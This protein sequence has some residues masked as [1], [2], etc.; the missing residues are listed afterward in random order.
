VKRPVVSFDVFDTLLTRA[1]AEPH[2]LF[3]ALGEALR[4]AG[5]WSGEPADFALIRRNAERTAR[6]EVPG[7]EV[8]LTEIHERLAEKLHW[9][10]AQRGAALRTEL[11]LEAAAIRPVAAKIA[12][13]DEA[14]L[15]CGRVLFLSD[16][17]LPVEFLRAALE[18]AGFFR[19]GDQLFVSGHTGVGKGGGLFEHVRRELG[20]D[21][22]SWTHHGDNALADAAAPRRHGIRAH[23]HSAGRLSRREHALRGA[24]TFAPPWRSRLAAA[25]RLGRLDAPSSLTAPDRMLWNIGATVA[26]PL[27]WAF[28]RWSLQE[29]ARRGAHDAYFLARG[30][31]IFW[32]IAAALRDPPALRRHYLFTSRLAFAGSFDRDNPTRL[33]ELAAP[34][35]AHHS[36]QQALTNLGL[37]PSAVELPDRWP[38]E[39]WGENLSRADRA[40]LADWLLGAKHLPRVQAALA[41]RALLAARYLRESGFANSA[42]AAVIDTGWMGTI[43]RNIEHLVGETDSPVA[44]DGFYLGLSSARE[45]ATQ[46]ERLGFTNVFRPLA[47]RRDTTH[48]ILLE[49]FARG[50]HGP[51]MGFSEKNGRIVPNFG[52]IPD[53]QQAEVR[54][55]QSAVL[56]FVA[57][58]ERAAELVPNADLA[59]AVIENYL[60]FFR[61]PER[62]EAEAISAI[63]HA[64]QMLEQRYTS[65]CRPMSCGE[66]LTACTDYHLR[67]PGWWLAGQAQLGPAPVLRV[68]QAAKHIKWWLKSRV[69]NQPL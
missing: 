13:V 58:A 20:L 50:D 51:L 40:D 15:A 56:S 59:C 23:L 62:S 52:Q 61:A 24:A 55:F 12:T 68:Y 8:S 7:G 37:D 19:A 14:R 67:P 17:Y 6:R 63:E 29:A 33:R 42:R 32:R 30:G 18:R 36:V 43:Q 25:A 57:H 16:M 47:L 39:R 27:C 9:S 11:E 66:A 46:G 60:D 4:G 69:L 38:R 54:L 53:R 64:D 49:L 26:G 10:S 1:W 28:T 21:F 48:L 22:A 3:V 34:S 44:V 35:L 31:Q 65:L 45:I 2:D 5:I 41:E